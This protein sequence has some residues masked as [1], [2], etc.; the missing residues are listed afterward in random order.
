MSEEP[1]EKLR[2]ALEL[3]RAAQN[4]RI[5]LFTPYAKQSEFFALGATKRQRMFNAGN[6]L[7]KSD[8]GAVETVFHATGEYPDWWVGRRFTRPV[9]IWACGM[10]ADATMKISQ[11]KLC[12]DPTISNSLGTGLIPKDKIANTTLG[13][14]VTGAYASIEV[15][16]I[17]GGT[18]SIS[19]KSYEQG[20]M[21]FQGDAIDFIW[22]D[23]EPEDYKIYTE[24]YTRLLDTG[25]C[26]II[27]YTPLKGETELFNSFHDMK[28]DNKGFVNMTGDDVLAEKN[29]HFIAI[30]A[31][32]GY[33][34]TQAGARQWYE[35][36]VMSWPVHERET[37]RAGRPTHGSGAVFDFLKEQIACAPIIDPPGHWR[38]GWGTD[39]GGM[40][41]T[42]GNYSHPFGAVLG[43]YDPLTDVIY[44]AHALRLQNQTPLAHAFAMKC[45]CAGAPV[46][47]PHDGN[48]QAARDNPETTAGL[49]KT[50]GLR[51]WH[52]WA[53]F[54]HG[55]YATE[56]GILE[57]HQRFA[58]G[59]LKI[60]DH[61]LEVW[62]EYRNYHR[63]ENGE[64]VRNKDDLMSALRILVMMLPRHGQTVPMGNLDGH[65]WQE[66]VNWMK[67]R[68][69]TAEEWSPITGQPY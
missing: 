38:M 34:S 17:S 4:N 68:R 57:M 59:R 18:S 28:D 2:K 42:T 19:F 29:N 66:G 22:M 60:C 58:T 64:I 30:A 61:L 15:K 54:K 37:R 26:M 56:T 10:S 65:R 20:W 32:E 35:K 50:Q 14:G 67:E 44:A 47:W 3:L 24:C 52:T 1:T 43:F 39:F 33:P 16:H 21:K 7:G 13:R 48:R 41:S 40:G 62:E 25:G 45:I 63:D 23:E 27:T 49:Y 31:A 6:R 53:T 11:G 12:G 55:G 5:M 8:S 51:M 9:K 36:E 69:R 46:F